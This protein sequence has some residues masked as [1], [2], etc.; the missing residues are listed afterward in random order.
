MELGRRADLDRAGI[1]ALEHGNRQPTFLTMV[2]LRGSLETTMDELA[3]GIDWNP[4]TLKVEVGEPPRK[5]E[6]P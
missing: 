4:D 5:P 6:E 3:A 1:W 2:K